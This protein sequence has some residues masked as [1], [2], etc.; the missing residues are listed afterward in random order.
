VSRSG[1][2]STIGG[3]ARFGL[4]LD[5]Q[6]PLSRTVALACLAEGLGLSEV[7]IPEVNHGRSGTTAAAAVALNTNRV[8]IGIGVLNMFWRHP[9]LLA[10]EA[11]T[12]DELSGG[13][14]RFGIGPSIWSLR[15][16][17]E[18][19]E[20]TRKP[21]TATVETLQML[22]AMLAGEDGIDPTLFAGRA[23]GRLDFEPVRKRIPL[24]V[25]AVNERMLEASGEIADGVELGG[26]TSLGYARWAR[27]RV[28]TGLARA[29]RSRSDFDLISLVLVSIDRDGDAA[30]RAVRRVIAYYL[31]RVEG[32]VTEKSGGDPDAIADAHR[33]W[34]ELGPE[35]ATE[36][37]SEDL[38]DVFAA[39]G[40][41]EA[42][43]ERLKA[44]IEVG[45][46]GVIAWWSGH[47]AD[48]EVG[49]R[50]LAA[51]VSH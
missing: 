2:A 41:P 11:A 25:G 45:L 49:L 28:Q 10:M 43:H 12:L 19:D 14:L 32:V 18:A 24:Y 27:D 40:T 3:R 15:N 22:R 9:S 4:A 1:D 38:I 6:V 16:L 29:G 20:R 37:L 23:D 5:N 42:V 51:E 47:G 21:L 48:P 17:G 7:W 46:D 44:Y 50:L 30:R 35:A 36:R 26:I 34:P 8:D 33:A 39:A 31:Y 13:R